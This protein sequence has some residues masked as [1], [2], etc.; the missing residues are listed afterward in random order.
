MGAAGSAMVYSTDDG[1]SP[2][3]VD[4]EAEAIRRLLLF[5]PQ[6]AAALVKIERSF[7]TALSGAVST[8]CFALFCVRRAAFAMVK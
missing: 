2:I 4:R 7:R 5:R 8:G 6:V 3:C 1:E